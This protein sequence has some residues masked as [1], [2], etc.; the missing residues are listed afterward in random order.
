MSHSHDESQ[1]ASARLRDPFGRLELLKRKMLAFFARL[2]FFRGW[3]R[4]AET[5]SRRTFLK[6]TTRQ[7]AGATAAAFVAPSVL[8][9]EP[10]GEVVLGVIGCGGRGQAL[11]RVFADIEGVR[12]GCVCDPDRSRAEKT[13]KSVGAQHAVADLRK[14]LDDRDVDAVV[15]ATPDHWHAPAALLACQA[16]KHVYV[17]KCP[18]HNIREGRLLIEAA[19]RHKCVVQV[20][21]QTRSHPVI[22]E[23][24]RRITEGAIGKV[25]MAKAWNSQRR[26]NIGHHEPTEPPAHLNYDLYVGPAPWV[27]YQANRYHYHWHW[28]HAFGTGD[29]GN[30]G[31]HELDVARWGLG[32]ATH[33]QLASGYGQK[34]FFDDDQ[35][36][37]DTQYVAF[38]YPGEGEI[39]QRRLLVYE[40]RIWSPYR[41]QELENG[42]AF[43]GTEGKM[44]L[45]KGWGWQR[46]GPR[47]KP[48]ETQR[49]SMQNEPHAEDFIDAMRSGR[50]PNADIRIGHLSA[51]L[52]HLGNIVARVGRPVRF[53]PQSE[54]IID[55]AEAER[56]VRREYRAGHWAAPR[57][58]A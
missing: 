7:A 54:Q 4:P 46:F 13:R 35:Q 21:T 28:W 52:T 16:G 44:I 53:D 51:T 19:E 37:P 45:G 47:D 38:E 34:L 9:R 23:A 31:I 2:P 39:G 1:A 18:T 5:S 20:G 25:L 17:E 29:M 6:E 22:Q 12:V 14:V 3:K 57:D 15:V 55:D 49:C 56:L 32:V 8:A 10:K 24:V 48:L 50:L 58:P 11:A 33:P 26:A 36:F 43:Y 27:P 41:Q 40:Q 42:V 30:D